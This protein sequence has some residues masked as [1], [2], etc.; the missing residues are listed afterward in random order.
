MQTSKKWFEGLLLGGLVFLFFLLLFEQWI[1][2]P[3]WL[4][5]AGR[6]HP[7]FVHFPIVLVLLVLLLYWIPADRGTGGIDPRGRGAELLRLITA[8]SAVFAAIM[9]LIL[10]LDGERGGS[11]LF[12]HKWGGTLVALLA[13]GYYFYYPRLLASR[14][15]GGP[16]TVLGAVFVLLTGHW[17]GNLTHG[18][19]YLLAPV[20]KKG[21]VHV[22]PEKALAYEHVIRPILEEKC[23]KCHNSGTAKGGLV[24]D[25][26]QGLLSGGKSGK[27]FVP[28][29]PDL[30]LILE[31]IHLPEEEKKHMPPSTRSQ[32]TAEETK[33]ITYWVRA[34]APMLN[35][36]VS[37]P[38]RD[39][40]RLLAEQWL[41]AGD[42]E[43]EQVVYDFSAADDKKIA[44]LSN[45]YRV[46]EPLGRNSPALSVH[47][48]GRNVF[49]GKSLDEL[50]EIKKQV[51][52]LNLARMPVS[53]NDLSTVS[54][55]ENLQKL[56][57]NYTDIT[58]K[59]LRTLA[60][61]KKLT[62]VSL[63]GT[64]IGA[65][66][67]GEFLG[68]PSLTEVYV[69]DTR[70]DTLQI[71]SLQKKYKKLHIEEGFVDNGHLNITLSS[72]LVDVE[73]SVFKTA[74]RVTMHHPYKGVQIKFTRD[75]S[76]PDSNHGEI[77]SGPVVFDTTTFLVARTFKP[78]W[79]PSRPSKQDYLQ[80][81]K[82]DSIR[83]INKPDTLYKNVPPEVLYDGGIGKDENTSGGLK[84]NSED[85]SWLGYRKNEASYYIYMKRD[86]L[87]KRIV[88]YTLTQPNFDNFPPSRVQLWG[89]PSKTQMHLMGSWNPAPLKSS[90]D[91]L[92]IAGHTLSFSPTR[93]RC[94]RMVVTPLKKMPEWSANKGKPAR[95]FISEILI[96]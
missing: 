49:T 48:Y 34:G 96:D 47:Y 89:G 63:S 81:L 53:D 19:D 13:A 69:W 79:H 64:A 44:A 88:F 95:L 55:L 82:P 26:I 14:R 9:G 30:S 51:T 70:I 24:M 2:V 10:S 43:E 84:L 36:L 3:S 83:F 59:G 18:D 15:L 28:G 52:E 12:W 68:L 90:D 31:R 92:A 66:A 67:L 46:I 71:S 93:V 61:L 21:R 57:L 85:G 25:K 38:G 91:T 20:M 35:T 50:L 77:Y 40:F 78:G 87:L 60:A 76:L 27:L 72:P 42:N 33:L 1:H 65:A 73:D 58:D 23:V 94:L 75:G 17:G 32:L 62:S 54:K 56:N 6:A 37:L 4:Q 74:I 8:L 29:K 41:R 45:N 16:L 86:T 7:L 22:A 11:V 5:V 39:S 80:S